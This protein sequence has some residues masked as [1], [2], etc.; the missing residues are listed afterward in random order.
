M[1]LLLALNK[2]TCLFYTIRDKNLAF[3]ITSQNVGFTKYDPKSDE[4]HVE[5]ENGRIIKNDK[6][7]CV[8]ALSSEVRLCTSTTPIVFEFSLLESHG[9]YKL[10]TRGSDVLA[11]GDFNENTQMYNAIVIDENEHRSLEKSH[12]FYISI[13]SY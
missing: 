5:M 8:S 3:T 9:I 13:N 2:A 10:Q 12:W 11:V 1:R 6:F 7:V 4:Q